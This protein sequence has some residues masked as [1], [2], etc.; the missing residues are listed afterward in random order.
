MLKHDLGDAAGTPNFAYIVPNLCHDGHDAPC[1]NGEPGGLISAD[2]FLRR[3]VPRILASPAFKQDGLLVVT[4]DEG[5]DGDA[6]CGEQPLPGGPVPG[7]FG[8]GGGRI[9]AVL[10]SPFIQPGTVSTQ[11]YNHYSFLRS[12]ENLFGLGYLGYAAAP[13]LHTFGSDVYTVPPR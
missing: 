10:L 11:T 5:T 4:F 8:P 1:K 12:I 9:G 2:A 6:C 7:Q 3:W 13:Q